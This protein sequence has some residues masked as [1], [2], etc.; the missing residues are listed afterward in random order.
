MGAQRGYHTTF[1][2]SSLSWD[3]DDIATRDDVA[4]PDAWDEGEETT[5]EVYNTANEESTTGGEE[6]DSLPEL[7][8]GSEDSGYDF[9]NTP[10][11]EEEKDFKA[12]AAEDK[13]KE[14]SFNKDNYS[15]GPALVAQGVSAHRTGHILEA[16]LPQGESRE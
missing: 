6:A 16:L 1:D 9:L 2:D 4:V 3:T 8:S 13:P 5:D 14:D 15:E 7:V 10:T 12:T 11:N